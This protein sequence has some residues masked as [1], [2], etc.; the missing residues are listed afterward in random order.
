[1]AN[2]VLEIKRIGGYSGVLLA[3]VKSARITVR[4]PLLGTGARKRVQMARST[5]CERA[6]HPVVAASGS[7]VMDVRELGFVVGPTI[8]AGIGG[9][10]MNHE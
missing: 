10:M 8:D 4:T 9:G 1:M 5:W 7:G 3:R 2:V 6:C